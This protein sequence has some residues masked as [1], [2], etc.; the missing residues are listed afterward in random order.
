VA[1]ELPLLLNNSV[2]L[3]A[4]GAGT[5]RFSVPNYDESWRVLLASVEVAPVPPATELANEPQARVYQDGRLL[6]GTYTGGLDSTDLN[7]MLQ[8]G[9]YIECRWTGG[10]VGAIATFTIQ[11]T[12]RVA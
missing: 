1:R 9:N 3:N 12:K 7:A 6:A 4:A 10:D 5:V 2:T 11:G 8:M